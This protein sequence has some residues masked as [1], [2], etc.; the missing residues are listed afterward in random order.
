MTAYRIERQGI[1]LRFGGD[2][3]PIPLGDLLKEAVL[4]FKVAISPPE[5]EADVT[6]VIRGQRPMQLQL[7]GG[8]GPEV[9]YEIVLPA[10]P[11]GT[12]VAYDIIAKPPVGNRVVELKASD[13]PSVPP[14]KFRVWQQTA[15]D[16]PTPPVPPVPPPPGPGGAHRTVGTVV[17]QQGGPAAGLK[18]RVA[19]PL[20]GGERRPLADTVTDANGKYSLSYDAAQGTSIVFVASSAPR[21][22]VLLTLPAPVETMEGT[23]NLVVPGDFGSAESEFERL[24]RAVQPHVGADPSALGR[25]RERGENRD[26][27]LLAQATGWDGRALALAADAHA[28]AATTKIPADALYAMARSGLPIGARALAAASSRSVE[29]ALDAAATTGIVSRERADAGLASFRAFAA[30]ARL[31]NKLRGTTSAP[32]DF[33][34]RAQL[35]QD[36]AMKFRRVVGDGED[37]D[38]WQRAKEAGVSERGVER[39]QLQGKLAF[40]TLNNAELSEHVAARIDSSPIELIQQGFYNAAKWAA[41]LRVELAGNDEERL[42]ALIPPAFPGGTVEARLAEYSE[43]LARRTRQCDPEAV[44]IQRL[45]D[46]AIDGVDAPSRTMVLA[47]MEKAGPLGFRLGDGVSSFIAANRTALGS[48]ADDNVM[49]GA[50]ARFSSLRNVAGSDELLGGIYKLGYESASD[51]AAVDKPVFLKQ[52]EALDPKVVAAPWEQA[53]AHYKATQVARTTY[54]VFDGFK[55]VDLATTGGV[56]GTV[57]LTPEQRAKVADKLKGQ[58]PTLENLFGSVDFCECT[59]C[60]SVLSPAAYLVDILNFIDPRGVR[61]ANAKSAFLASYGSEYALAPPYHYLKLRRPDLEVIPLTCANT[62][63]SLPYIDLTNEV[64]EQLV[65]GKDLQAFDTGDADSADLVAE[66]Q[67]ITWDAYEGP[68]GKGG[69]RAKVFPRQLPFDLPLEMVRAFFDELELPIWQLRE[70]VLRPQTIDGWARVWFERLGL[71][72]RDVQTFWKDDSFALLGFESAAA[73]SLAADPLPRTSAR[74][75]QTLARRLDVSYVEL[76]DLVRTRFVNPGIDQLVI[77]DQLGLDPTLI[78]HHLDNPAEP[79]GELGKTLLKL[80]IKLNELKPLREKTLKERTLRVTAPTLGCDYGERWL[81]FDLAPALDVSGAWA[82]V[83]RRLSFFV[84]LRA[85]LN[86]R[87]ADVGALAARQQAGKQVWQRPPWTIAELDAALT[88]LFPGASAMTAASWNKEAVE[89]ALVYLANLEEVLDR[90]RDRVSREELVVLWADLPDAGRA[91]LFGRLFQSRATLAANGA[92]ADRLGKRFDANAALTVTDFKVSSHLETIREAIGV[93]VD[94]LSSVIT[95]AKLAP[96]ELLSVAALSTIVRHTTLARALGLSVADTLE[97]LALT[98]KLPLQKVPGATLDLLRQLQVIEEAGIELRVLFDVCWGRGL[99]AAPTEA[100]DAALI[101][102]RAVATAK[103][104]APADK[105]VRD[106]LVLRTLAAQLGLTEA[107][108]SRLVNEQLKLADKLLATTEQS[109]ALARLRAAARLIEVFGFRQLE[110]DWLMDAGLSFS[111]IPWEDATIV[112]A[113]ATLAALQ[114]TL[115]LAAARTRFAGSDRLVAV[116]RAAAQKT[117]PGHTAAAREAELHAALAALTRMP[118]AV[119]VQVLPSV[120][121]KTVTATL[122][123]VPALRTAAALTKTIEAVASLVLVGMKPEDT[124]DVISKEVDRTAAQKQRAALKARFGRANWRT[125][126]KPIFDRLRIK[127]R[128]ALVAF[129]TH[130]KN[131]DGSSKFGVTQEELFHTLLLDPG[132]EPPVLASRIQRAILSVQTFVQQ[133]LS[134]IEL[135]GDPASPTGVDPRIIDKERWQ[136]MRQYRLWEVNRKFFIWPENWLAPEFRDDKSHL[137]RELESS[138]LQSNV[139][140]DLVGVALQKYVEGL[141]R[142]ARLDMLT[143]YFEAKPAGGGKLHVVARTQNQPSQY[144]YRTCSYGMWSPWEP[145]D[146][147]CEGE[148]LV[149]TAWRGRMRLLWVTFMDQPASAPTKEQTSISSGMTIEAPPPTNDVAVQLHWVDYSRGKWGKRESTPMTTPAC[150]KGAGHK[151]TTEEEKRRFFVNAARTWL[152]GRELLQIHVTQA[153]TP[154]APED[155]PTYTFFSR[156]APPRVDDAVINRKLVPAFQVHPAPEATKW[157]GAAPLTAKFKA[158][159]TKT[160]GEDSALEI[161]ELSVLARGG[162]F[163]LLLPSNDSWA[164]AKMTPPS[165]SSGLSMA[166]FRPHGAIHFV[167]RGS[168]DSV[169]SLW[170]TLNGWFINDLTDSSDLEPDSIAPEPPRSTPVVYEVPGAGVLCVAYATKNQVVEHSWAQADGA[171]ANSD[172]SL[173]WTTRVVFTRSPTGTVP[174]GKPAGGV[175]APRRGLVFRLG[176]Q[177]LKAVEG[178]VPA[179]LAPDLPPL[180]GDP[181][182]CLVTDTSVPPK[183]V[184]RHVFLAASDGHLYELHSDEAGLAW[185]PTQMTAGV[186][187]PAHP[188]KHAALSSFQQAATKTLHVVYRG[189]DERVYELWRKAGGDWQLRPAVNAL[190]PAQGDPVAFA[191]P[192]SEMTYV[193]YQTDLGTIALLSRHANAE[194]KYQEW[195]PQSEGEPSPDTE[196]ASPCTYVQDGVVEIAYRAA[197]GAIAYL[198]VKQGSW[199]SAPVDLG[200]VSNGDQALAAPFFF[201]STERPHTFFVEPT[202]LESTAHEWNE[203]IVTEKEL[204]PP[205]AFKPTPIAAGGKVLPHD[206]SIVKMNEHMSGKPFADDVLIRTSKGTLGPGGRPATSATS[207]NGTRV[208]DMRNMS[209]A[210]KKAYARSM[211]R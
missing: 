84:R 173:E 106:Q 28:L 209:D 124:I 137:F 92:F 10:M 202:L 50:V 36:D 162:D 39:L 104:V 174:I 176:D 7:R 55:R 32:K 163:R 155:N 102:L 138:L 38:I 143:M 71:S 53:Q 121:P 110:T 194:F 195:S 45:K 31:S 177:L 5:R 189:A 109:G 115:A 86:A 99:V 101:A 199:G 187:A 208:V 83:F 167:Y 131:D 74:N 165:A 164:R 180:A 63:V 146:V 207:H 118:Q 22:D 148:H 119:L 13:A 151:A 130:E 120:A 27:S 56:P 144:F 105:K 125:R 149:F 159:I 183:V 191:D 98:G 193:S 171:L 60:L 18:L 47:F 142:I 64:L 17:L 153:A 204:Q 91:H 206:L 30:E 93:S 184:S 112:E 135:R 59:E 76:E 111:L 16:P 8:A 3:T 182:T 198:T 82:L 186:S 103:S 122:F 197:G 65:A 94:D 127:Q 35:S 14:L 211:P 205:A 145:I 24:S 54:S 210:D 141:E 154:G 15:P 107:T 90:A 132:M 66:P 80:G 97:L 152:N 158:S 166:Q 181:A 42:S 139:D 41:L 52:L 44:T 21:G 170:T 129:L 89:T 33:I 62:N 134:G 81:A 75:A 1:T 157:V 185:A 203:W 48:L 179:S 156:L 136:W 25:A 26:I 6:L 4:R 196:L 85:R 113:S 116:L 160:D 117:E 172:T 40:L 96:G 88:A 49:L 133:C 51:I 169:E 12:E 161:A 20:F 108:V 192:R 34:A 72:P 2:D 11:P 68:D 123:E 57:M 147:G 69:L 73:A 178:E 114:E 78:D 29:A 95:A 128:D 9:F 100:E 200:V 46:G 126:A 61:W 150:W 37:G 23:V 140:E 201:E 77:L 79:L 19:Q 175:F 168:G 58:F 67:N 190:L 87:L 70:R 43:E 188:A